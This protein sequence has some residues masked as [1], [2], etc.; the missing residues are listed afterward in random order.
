MSDIELPKEPMAPIR[1]S[2]IP[3]G[4]EWGFQLKWD[5]VRLLAELQQNRIRLFSRYMGD[6]TNIYPEAVKLLT[7]HALRHQPLLL[8][9][10]AVIFDTVKQRPDFSQ[11]LQRE[12]TRSATARIKG[13]ETSHFIYVLFDLLHY[14]GED[15]RD[16]PY[17]ERHAKL[18]ELFPDKHPQLFVTDLISDGDA[19]WDWVDAN[20]W[21]GIIS[22]RL[23]SPYR[24]GKHHKDWF[25][26]KTAEVHE[27]D[28]I[29]FIIREGRVAS[30]IMVK[31]GALFG[32]VSLGLDTSMKT[33]LLTFGREQERAE[34][35]LNR[36]QLPYELRR[37][38]ILWLS[39]P[40]KG[41]VTGLEVTSA[42]QLRH[43]KL[44]HIEWEE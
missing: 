20:G 1:E 21:E 17:H 12:R 36:T 11:I 41:T 16:R 25:K 30:L 44:V 4:A 38:Q 18:L 22:K 19:L 9:G 13:R 29:G 8:D 5:G 40:L 35:P 23:S 43:P 31:N 42:G 32:R 33:R 34:A 27:V 26:K 10:E 24:E 28:F 14:G 39:K 15:W 6:K 3:T 37:E 7:E 2:K